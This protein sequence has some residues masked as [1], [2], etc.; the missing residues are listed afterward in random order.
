MKTLTKILAFGSMAAGAL[1]L[2]ATANAALFYCDENTDPTFMTIDTGDGPG[3]AA[4]AHTADGNDA[5]DPFFNDYVLLWKDD[6]ADGESGPGPDPFIDFTGQLDTSG[7]FVLVEGLNDHLLVFK[8]GSGRTDPNLFA[9]EIDGITSGSWSLTDPPPTNGLSH[10]AI[11]GAPVDVP[12]PATLALLGL[13]LVGFG[14][15]RRRKT[16]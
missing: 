14:L 8:F 4:C 7:T 13:G 6:F 10:V 15:S 3:T 5:T 12:E 1:L 2:S 11:Y 9:F 16:T